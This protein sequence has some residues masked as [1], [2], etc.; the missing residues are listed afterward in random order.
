VIVI[1]KE[2][3][4]GRTI[5]IKVLGPHDAGVPGRVAPDVFDDPVDV[6]R[7]QEFLADP[8]QHLAVAVDAGVVAGFVSAVHYLHPDKPRPGL[9]VN[10]LSVSETHRRRG[11]GRRPCA[12]A[13]LRARRTR[14][15][16]T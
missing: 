11:L 2:R 15:R 13:P 1:D 14:P 9:W 8:R 3:P 10:E 16:T 6:R 12:S 4:T 5:D 7:A